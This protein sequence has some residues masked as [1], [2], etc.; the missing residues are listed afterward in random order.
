MYLKNLSCAPRRA[1][2][3]YRA[4]AD[5]NVVA[6]PNA[7]TTAEI[8][9]T[10]KELAAVVW[11]L[12]ANGWMIEGIEESLL[13]E[14]RHA[15]LKYHRSRRPELYKVFEKPLPVADDW[16]RGDKNQIIANHPQN[17]RHAIELLGVEFRHNEFAGL[18]NWPTGELRD[19]G[20]IRARMQIQE[21]Y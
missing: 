2:S 9:A 16:A 6:F 17:I 8:K 5:Y 13:E 3:G 4:D 19:A 14:P 11:V 20:A 1:I 18:D 21:A 15:H 12:R 7:P 10:K